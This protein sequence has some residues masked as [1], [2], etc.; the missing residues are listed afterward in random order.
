MASLRDLFIN[1]PP[2]RW[3]RCG[4]GRVIKKLMEGVR[5]V[6]RP[7]DLLEDKRKHLGKFHSTFKDP[8]TRKPAQPHRSAGLLRLVQNLWY[9]GVRKQLCP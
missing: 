9:H 2:C 3:S 6:R 1:Q 7:L 8:Q 5:G 4:K